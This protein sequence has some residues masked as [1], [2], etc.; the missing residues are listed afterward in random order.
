MFCQVTLLGNVGRDPELRYT[1]TGMAVCNF[2]IAVNRSR[3]DRNTNERIDETTWWKI[4]VWGVQAENVN[5]YVKKGQ[6][7]LV[8]GSRVA[9]SAYSSAEGPKASLELT[10]DLVKFLGGRQDA[11][12]GDQSIV[13]DDVTPLDEI[14][15]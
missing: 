12:D 13:H 3:T 15:F 8:V 14:P 4:T 11:H 7:V 6:R 5:Q 10:A 2:S 1:P 9:A